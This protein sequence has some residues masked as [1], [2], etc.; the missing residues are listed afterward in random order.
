LDKLFKPWIIHMYRKE[1]R[2]LL[3]EEYGSLKKLTYPKVK[4]V[5]QKSGLNMTYEAYAYALYLKR[6][7]F[8]EFQ[9]KTGFPYSYD[10]LR[11]KLGDS[12]MF[13]DTPFHSGSFYP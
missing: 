13:K 1:L 3:L 7:R 9:H 12:K 10:H 2:D 11:I 5:M 6:T 8:S 4:A